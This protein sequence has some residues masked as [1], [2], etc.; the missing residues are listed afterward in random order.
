MMSD[1]N[2]KQICLFLGTPDDKP[3]LPY[4]KGMFNGLATYVC[5]DPISLLTHLGMYCDARKITAI[6]TTSTVILRKLVEIRGTIVKEPSI[7]NYAGSL[8]TYDGREIVI[9]NPLRQL[10]TVSYGAFIA[11]RFISKVTA[12]DSWKPS[13]PFDW[14]L[15]TASNIE[16]IY[17]DLSTAFAIAADIETFKSPLSIRCI[18]YT[19]I[20]IDSSGHIDTRSYVLPID[21][22]FA[23]TWMRKINRLPVRKIFQNGKYDQSYLLRYNAA[24]DYWLHDTAHFM[25]AWYSELPKDLAFINSFFVRSSIYHKDL[26]NTND[27]FEYYKYNALDTWVTANVWIAQMLE[28]PDWARRNYELAFPLVYPC[29]LAE[30]TGIKRD[31]DALLIARRTVES[32]EQVAVDS[33]RKMLRSPSFNPGS[34][35]QVKNLLKLL[36]CGDIDSSNEKDI[37]KAQLR[38][39]LNNRILALVLTIRGLR[40]LRTTYLRTD[41]DAKTTG[42]HAGEGGSKDFHG[43]VIYALNP[44]GTDTARLASRE[45][46]FWTGTQIQNIPVGEPG[47]P[48]HTKTTICAEDGF[49]LAEGD[50]EKAESWDTAYIS[51]DRGLIEAVNSPS[52][53]HSTN[54]NRFFGIPYAD[55]YDDNTKKAKNKPLRNLSKRTNHGFNY[56]MG[57]ATLIDTMGLDKIW[58]AG[59]LLHLEFRDPIRIAQ[60]LL[61]SVDKVYPGIRKEYYGSVINEVGVHRSLTSRAYHH[62]EYNCRTYNPDDYIRDGD[63]KRYCFGKPEKNKLD[64]NSYVAHC[65][66]SLN[67]RTLNEAFLKVFYEI[68]LPN[69]LSFRLHAQIHDSILFSYAEGHSDLATAVQQLMQIA[70]TIRDVSG[71]IRTFTVPASLKLGTSDKNTGTFNRAKYWSETE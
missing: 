6:V 11:R 56:N 17:H 21:S 40:K 22:T 4:L 37:A 23:L 29:L 48:S 5:T 3:Y 2:A 52:D 53:F 60:H 61:D 28:A 71:I 44:H 25:H 39:P 69:P 35:L 59:R 32:Q 50:L 1:P 38:H 49:F 68:A 13:T 47:E 45:H 64:L 42:I 70:V 20:Y 15:C 51:G 18:G 46:H 33:L 55:I 9:I 26:A 67:A 19:G 16:G 66:Q 57:A 63:W 58:E 7:N 34:P 36:G 27:L 65:P 41:E 24:A 10:F 54:A 31:Q 43:R 14:S 30:M 8:F 12:R 62:T